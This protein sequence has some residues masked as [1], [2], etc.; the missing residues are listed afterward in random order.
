MTDKN[1]PLWVTIIRYRYGSGSTEF[2]AFD[3]DYDDVPKEMNSD[4]VDDMNFWDKYE[5][6]HQDGDYT[7]YESGLVKPVIGRGRNPLEAYND[8]LN[9]YRHLEEF[10]VYKRK[11]V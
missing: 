1:V 8:L 9:S 11:N 7:R 3:C 10:W 5:C 4:D 6:E 2:L